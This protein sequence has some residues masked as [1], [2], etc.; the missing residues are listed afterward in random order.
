MDIGPS[1]VGIDLGDIDTDYLVIEVDNP[2]DHL[3]KTP[4]SCS[5]IEHMHLWMD[6]IIFFLDFKE[7]ERT[8]ST[9]SHLLGFFK[10]WVVDNKRFWHNFLTK[11]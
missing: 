4:R 1:E 9:V 5:D 2:R 11:E 3:D 10:I 6:N 8:A 7:L